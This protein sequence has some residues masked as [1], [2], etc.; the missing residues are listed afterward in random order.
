VAWVPL[1]N[2]LISA[3]EPG[4]AARE[5]RHRVP[6]QRT[7]PRRP[8]PRTAA[9][10]LLVTLGVGVLAGSASRP[11]GAAASGPVYAYAAPAPAAPATATAA[12][13]SDLPDDD[14]R[15]ATVPAA[16]PEPEPSSPAPDEP[17]SEP[18]PQA[19]AAA[20]PE[21]T[22]EATAT[23]EPTATATPAPEAPPAKHVVIVSLTGQNASAFDGWGPAPYLEHELAAQ[24]A[25]LRGYRATSDK[26]SLANGVALLAGTQCVSADCAFDP[27]AASL[28]QRLSDEARSWKAYVDEPAPCSSVAAPGYDPARN[29]FASMSLPDCGTNEVPTAQLEGDF[30]DTDSAPSL[31]YVIPDICHDGRDGADCPGQP[32]TGLE[33]AD[34]WLKEWIPKVTDSKAF[35]DDGLLVVLFDGGNLPLPEPYTHE[36]PPVGALVISGDFAKPGAQTQHAYDHLSLLR[37]ISAS[38]GVPAPGAAAED[39]VEPLGH[40]V[41]R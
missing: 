24:G 22:P 36:P 9:A 19:A 40:D 16:A 1:V 27:D 20:T 29:P 11:R 35:A 12:S 7:D 39:D 31:A 6:G 13:G 2:N 14:G 8:H 5:H 38:L 21:P 30:A 34:A 18:A 41:L 26:G 33:R 4:V 28:P 17:T 25:L 3:P 23:P 37:T 10:L 32:A 15:A